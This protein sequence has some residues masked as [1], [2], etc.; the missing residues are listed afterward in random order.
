MTR[1]KRRT[2]NVK[3]GALD[4]DSQCRDTSADSVKHSKTSEKK[5]CKR[6]KKSCK[7]LAC[8]ATP[9]KRSRGTSIHSGC[10]ADS[11]SAP[12]QSDSEQEYISPT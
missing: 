8:M 12:E 1:T 10:S 5:S 2:D 6:L 3:S 4:K 7:C 11:Q 9:V